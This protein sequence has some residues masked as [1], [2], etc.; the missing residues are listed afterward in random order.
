MLGSKVAKEESKKP[1]ASKK[2]EAGNGEGSSTP[3]NGAASEPK[4]DTVESK[5]FFQLTGDEN[6][7]DSEDDEDNEDAGEEAEED[8]DDLGNAYETF[9]IARVLYTKQLEALEGSES[10][11]K[12]KDKAELT[13]EARAIKAKLADCH[14][15]LAEISMESEKFHGA[16]ADARKSLELQE[17]LLPSEHDH[18]IEAHYQLSLAL[19]FA[20]VR[21]VR[22]DQTGP[23][24]SSNGTEAKEEEEEVDYELRK[25]AATQTELCVRC[26]EARLKTAREASTQPGIAPEKKRELEFLIKDKSEILD[27]MKVRVSS[28]IVPRS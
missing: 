9:E 8:Q 7:T 19:E 4:E 27:D 1:K 23:L 28:H 5:P 12:G 6:W 13:P 2:V 18:V 22:E 21:K 17:E 24:A 16:I 26:L 20:S 11:D 25:E 14:G 10:A 3:A 15:F